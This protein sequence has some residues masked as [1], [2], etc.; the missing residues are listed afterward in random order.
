MSIDRVYMEIVTHMCVYSKVYMETDL[1]N[2][3]CRCRFVGVVVRV[4]MPACVGDG[5]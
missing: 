2:Y 1:H 5:L 4:L 3:G